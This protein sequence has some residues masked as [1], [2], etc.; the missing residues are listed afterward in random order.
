MLRF[1][2][3]FDC[4]ENKTVHN[5][6]VE[7]EI[8]MFARLSQTPGPRSLRCFDHDVVVVDAIYIVVYVMKALYY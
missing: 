6:V 4:T 2:R 7:K 8:G 1:S 5:R 3:K